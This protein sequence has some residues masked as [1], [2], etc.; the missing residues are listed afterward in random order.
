MPCNCPPARRSDLYPS[1]GEILVRVGDCVGVLHHS[2]VDISHHG[3]TFWFRLLGPELRY[4]GARWRCIYLSERG[5]LLHFRSIYFFPLMI[6]SSDESLS[7]L[8]SSVSPL[9][10]S[11]SYL[12]LSFLLLTTMMMTVMMRT[13]ATTDP[14]MIGRRKLVLA[15]VCFSIIGESELPQGLHV[16]ASL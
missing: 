9:A 6:F 7:F 5:S 16:S 14:M 3:S 15:R 10:F 12:V 2:L 4:L 8:L 13:R 11:S 1:L